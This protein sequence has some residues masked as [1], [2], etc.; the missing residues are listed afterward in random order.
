MRSVAV[1]PALVVVLVFALV[2]V[3]CPHRVAG[4]D[5]STLTHES[6][7][8]R[9]QQSAAH[10]SSM[11]GVIKARLPGLEGV[12]VNATID[13]AGRAPGDLFVAVRSFFEVPQ[14]VLVSRQND[15]SGEVTL[16]D[17]SSGA[18]H[19]FRGPAT[20]KTLQRVL[21]VPLAPDDVV[22]LLLARPPL[23]ERPGW[24][25][26]RVRLIGVDEEAGTYT[27]R[28]E[29]AGRGPL[30]VTVDARNDTLLQATV[31]RGDGRELVAAVFEAPRVVAGVV[32]AGRVKLTVIETGQELVLEVQEA[33]WN[34]AIADE[35]F[36][37]APPD[38]MKLEPL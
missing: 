22:A 19:F 15:G 7:R 26:P 11:Q 5:V 25:P 2:A 18:P 17:A 6:V 23:D 29:R 35:A 3:G 34:E 24:P 1:L 30:V 37:L 33:T 9:L 13:V 8:A 4:V 27:A 21:G 38:G 32:F 36:T 16:Y 28:I 31:A 10:R 14:Q 12:V 20:E